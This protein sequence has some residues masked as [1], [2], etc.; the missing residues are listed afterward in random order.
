MCWA[1][2]QYE[3][4]T[5][6]DCTQEN[7]EIK[8]NKKVKKKIKWKRVPPVNVYDSIMLMF[9]F[10]N[11][12]IVSDEINA[13]NS[14][15]WY[16]KQRKKWKTTLEILIRIT[17]GSSCLFYSFYFVQIDTRDSKDVRLYLYFRWNCRETWRNF[18]NL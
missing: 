16:K 15:Q 4:L 7:L 2:E 3:T 9:F 1:N 6:N 10:F 11:D 8:K 5:K 12:K 18:D 13:V 17:N 14:K